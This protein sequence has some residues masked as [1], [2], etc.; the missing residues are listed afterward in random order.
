MVSFYVCAII[1]AAS[2][3][4]S[5]GFSVMALRLAKDESYNNAMYAA[6]RSVALALISL[7][8]FFYHATAF[9]AAI[10]LIMIL[11]QAIDAV[12]GVRIRSA[13]KT[14]GPAATAFFNLLALVW[15]LR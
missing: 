10:A 11:V 8:P 6:A 14:F 3:F 9:L 2:A 4:T 7:V 1:T 12:I 15:L 13:L 5:F